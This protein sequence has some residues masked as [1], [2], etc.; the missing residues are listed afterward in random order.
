M[1]AHPHCRQGRSDPGLEG[2]TP[3]AQVGRPEGDIFGDRGQEHL[4]AR[5]LEDDA[6]PAAHLQQVLL[7]HRDAL[8][9]RR[10]LRGRENVVEAEQQGWSECGRL[11]LAR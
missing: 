9:V 5:I 6:N 2:L 3:E 11:G 1:L 7:R 10:A 8:D 4:V